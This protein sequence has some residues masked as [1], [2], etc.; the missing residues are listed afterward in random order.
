M[1]LTQIDVALLA[2]GGAGHLLLLY[3]L[4]RR[5]LYKTFPMF[6]AYIFYSLISDLLF[7]IVFRHVSPGTYFVA[8]FANS[9]PEFLLQLGILIEVARNVLNPVKR[10]L[11]KASLWVFAAMLVSGTVLA[12]LLSAESK[13]SELTRWSQY[14]VQINFSFAILRLVIFSAIA[15]FSQMLGIGWKNHVLQ[16]A[17]GFASYSIIILLVELLHHFTGVADSYR[18]HLHEQIRSLG[19]CMALGYWS[20]VLAKKEVPRREFSPKMASFLLS[21]ADT[22]RDA[23]SGAVRL[24]RK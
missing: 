22:G 13:P 3:L 1:G 12:L 2:C 19:W 21:I 14:F 15:A 6:T 24:Y 23:R 4:L 8:Y 16:I 20:Y 18:Y 7:L 17:T 9:V 5:R 11:P 10:S